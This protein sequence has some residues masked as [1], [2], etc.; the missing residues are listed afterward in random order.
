M[1]KYDLL[2]KIKKLNGRSYP[3]T[4]DNSDEEEKLLNEL[5]NTKRIIYND[6][7]N[8]VIINPDWKGE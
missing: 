5:L 1:D 7:R 8:G 2:N 6:Q 4:K 3:K